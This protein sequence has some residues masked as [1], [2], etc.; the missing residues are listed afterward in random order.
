MQ[1]A[2][3]SM[4]AT[5]VNVTLDLLVTVKHA[6]TLMNVPDECWLDLTPS[7]VMSMPSVLTLSA[8]TL[9]HV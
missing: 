1:S 3:I 4:V 8:V 7:H 2:I 9:V 5:L 6:W